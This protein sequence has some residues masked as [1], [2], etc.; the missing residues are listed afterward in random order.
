M[1]D[2]R[3]A[4]FTI[5][6]GLI[7][8]GTHAYAEDGAVEGIKAQPLDSALKEFA[9]KTG[10]KVIYLAEVAAGLKSKGSEPDVA[11]DEMLGQ[12]LAST[13]LTYEY[14]GESTVAIEPIASSST[15]EGN[16][17]P[18]KSQVGTSPMLVAENQTSAAENHDNWTNR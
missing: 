17:I 6:V 7:L 4:V 16:E 14:I 15:T 12:L 3:I 9:E 1:A 8:H 18:Q 13:G 10:M 5:L 2:V 11:N